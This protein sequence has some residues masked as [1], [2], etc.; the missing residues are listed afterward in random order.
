M[1]VLP[2]FPHCH[3]VQD[4]TNDTI[5]AIK[6]VGIKDTILVLTPANI[7]GFIVMTT[8]PGVHAPHT[9]IQYTPSHRCLCQPCSLHSPGSQSP[10]ASFS[11]VVRCQDAWGGRRHVG[12]GLRPCGASAASEGEVLYEQPQL[13]QHNSSSEPLKENQEET[14][15]SG[16]KE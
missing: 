4:N 2:A 12:R 15:W 14:R 3:C 6:K 11:R 5:V 16:D 10:V 7:K 8:G 9:V 13:P 1:V